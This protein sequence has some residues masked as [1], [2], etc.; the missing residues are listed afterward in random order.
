[1]LVW[2][3]ELCSCPHPQPDLT[4]GLGSETQSTVPWNQATSLP[5]PVTICPRVEG[6]WARCAL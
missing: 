2:I 6:R 4:L 1:M 5:V 3:R